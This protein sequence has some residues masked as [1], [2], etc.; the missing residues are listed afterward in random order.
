MPGS[1]DKHVVD[2]TAAN[3]GRKVYAAECI[4]CHG[5]HARGTDNGADLVRSEVVLND[6]YGSTIGPF[7]KKGHPT[8]TTPVPRLEQTQI[9]DLSH[10]IHQE[11]YNTL[12]SAACFHNSR[13]GEHGIFLSKGCWKGITIV[14]AP[15]ALWLSVSVSYSSSLL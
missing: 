13:R 15:A 11:V 9:A 2:D 1:A 7:L 3:R 4:N 5:P 14:A 10:T 8:Q 6:R 12:R